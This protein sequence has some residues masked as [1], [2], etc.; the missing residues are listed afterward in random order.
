M[1]EQPS[2]A[3][4]RCPGCGIE[5]PTVTPPATH[6]SFGASA[7]CWQLYGELLAREFQDPSSF[8][9]HQMTVDV[10]AVQHPRVDSR[11]GIRSTALHLMTLALWIEDGTD[12]RH[13][14]LLHRRMAGSLDFGR[15]EPPRPNGTM[16]VVDVLAADSPDRHAALVRAWGEDIWRAWEPHHETVR[17]WLRESLPE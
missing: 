4:E 12:P 16:T 11:R 9:L 1:I 15:L 13:G 10:Y 5:L 17:R 2:P 6:P 3:L 7:S 8:P 14:P